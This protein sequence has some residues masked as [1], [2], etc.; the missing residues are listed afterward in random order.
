M[1][2]GAGQLPL[3]GP[4]DGLVEGESDGAQG[5]LVDAAFELVGHA[6]VEEQ[7]F[8]AEVDLLPGNLGR[9]PGQ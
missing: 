3:A 9:G 7:S 1:T 5:R 2:A 8:N 6:G 4:P